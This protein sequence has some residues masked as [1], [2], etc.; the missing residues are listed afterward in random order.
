MEAV[1]QKSSWLKSLL[2]IIRGAPEQQAP[3]LAVSASGRQY[4][5]SDLF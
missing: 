3:S 2:M 5:G 1:T 4:R